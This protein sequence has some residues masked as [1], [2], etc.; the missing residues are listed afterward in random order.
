[1]PGRLTRLSLV[2][3]ARTTTAPRP[4]LKPRGLPPALAPHEVYV[5]TSPGD[6]AIYG[7]DLLGRH[8][9]Q[10][11][12]GHT[13]D[14]RASY[15]GVLLRD[16][17]IGY[18]DYATAVTVA[19]EEL[20]DDQLVI[21]PASGTSLISSDAVDVE[22]SP[23]MAAVP[24]PGAAMDVRCDADT[25]HLVMRVNR[26]ALDVHLS[27][28]LGRTLDRPLEFDLAFDLS[29]STS[30]RWN[31]AVQMLHAELLDPRSLLHESV[32]LG[33]M[34]EFVMSSLLYSQRS[35]YSDELT[36]SV[37]QTIS[38]TVRQARDHIDQNLSRPLAVEDI[39]AAVE[40]SVRTL[41]NNF[42]ADLGQTPTSYIR[43]RRLERARA[44][45]ADARPGTGVT[46]TDVALRWGFTHL[47]RFAV[48]YRNRFG[49]SPSQTLR[50]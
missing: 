14:F 33:Q 26:S 22:A 37:G 50:S 13:G 27:R 24:R 1:M 47:G 46:V 21:V 29:S 6:A 42:R 28:L 12:A 35:S 19:V 41:Q 18:L 43:N 44:D 34:E 39:A 2:D 7:R 38:A 31:F 20:G 15:H 30:S 10:V 5:S 45:L 40:V 23:V 36:R 48:V 4:R 17:T 25:A 49:E 16:V 8:Q 9:V 11:D 32:G 3:T